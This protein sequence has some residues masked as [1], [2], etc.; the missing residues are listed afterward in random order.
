MRF[1][2]LACILVLSACDGAGEPPPPPQG[3]FPTREVVLAEAVARLDADGSGGIEESEYLRFATDASTFRV[4]D[5]DGDGVLSP[6]ELGLAL[7]DAD[8][9]D[10][11]HR[12]QVPGVGPPPGSWTGG[13]R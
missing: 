4:Y 11:I 5:A 2:P 1:L 6:S 3:R 13:A 7:G 10:L 8:P 12:V 9:N